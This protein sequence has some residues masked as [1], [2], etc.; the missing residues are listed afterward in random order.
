[1]SWDFGF[2]NLNVLRGDNKLIINRIIKNLVYLFRIGNFFVDLF[3]IVLASF[4]RVLFFNRIVYLLEL[5]NV[6]L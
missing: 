4:Y 1:M 3:E 6:I 5:H 2:W